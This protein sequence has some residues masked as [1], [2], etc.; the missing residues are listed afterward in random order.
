M[1]KKLLENYLLNK[2]LQAVYAVRKDDYMM[3]LYAEKACDYLGVIL[4]LG[5]MKAS[6]LQAL[7]YEAFVEAHIKE[8]LGIKETYSQA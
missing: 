2:R 4:D 7:G 5:L 3:K 8:S 1:K 6:K